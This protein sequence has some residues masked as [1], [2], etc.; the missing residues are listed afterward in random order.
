MFGTRRHPGPP[1]RA[2]I[3]RRA[4]TFTGL[5][6]SG[7]ALTAVMAPLAFGAPGGGSPW[8]Q[9]GHDPAHSGVSNTEQALTAADVNQLVSLFSAPSCRA[10]RTGR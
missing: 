1:T 3:R 10:P 8:T 6:I 4:G 5:A 9:F 2:R 7:V